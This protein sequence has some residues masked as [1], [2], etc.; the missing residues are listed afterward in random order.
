ML[1]AINNS[2]ISDKVSIKSMLKKFNLLSVNQLAAQI[3]LVK[4]WMSVNKEGCPLSLEAYKR[5]DMDNT[6]D[7]RVQNNRIFKGT[8]RLI[9]S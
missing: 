8:C 1:R 5:R 3:K 4:V 9:K 2:K 7:L 6:H